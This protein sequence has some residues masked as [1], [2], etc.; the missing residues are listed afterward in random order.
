M[1]PGQFRA[2][3]SVTLSTAVSEGN[4]EE[5]WLQA[6]EDAQCPLCRSEISDIYEHSAETCEDIAEFLPTDLSMVELVEDMQILNK[7]HVC[8]ACLDVS[9]V[10]M[11]L[12]CNDMLCRPCATA[13]GRLTATRHHQV[14]DLTSLTAERL[15]YSR[16]TPCQDHSEKTSE[17]FCP[18]HGATICHLCAVSKHR[19]CPEVTE[20]ELKVEQLRSEL[21]GLVSLL[22]TR[23]AEIKRAITQLDEE[24]A[25]TEKRTH[26][27]GDVRNLA[28]VVTPTTLT[29]N[30]MDLARLEDD[31]S[32]LGDMTVPAAVVTEQPN[33][34][35]FHVNHG[36]N[37]VLVDD[38]T[39]AERT[40][41]H[42][43]GTVVL[44]TPMIIDQLYEVCIIDRKR[45]R[46]FTSY[47][48]PGVTFEEPTG[49]FP[50]K[51]P[52][53]WD[54]AILIGNTYV[55]EYGKKFRA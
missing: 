10:T 53:G 50:P 48:R 24:L 7:E 17:L 32:Q 26:A 25:Q 27:A 14:E 23:E 54:S 2:L 6:N 1:V 52:F 12:N 8:C 35:R 37:I 5:N 55:S 39:S 29:I 31:L 19:A 22:Q 28:K 9:A 34:L 11:C 42:M 30:K 43:S 18:S 40:D 41:G 3:H 33:I 51:D 45:S 47:V 21:D 16:P 38:R 4:Q 20:L 44:D 13:H 46:T 36:M 15:A 49:R